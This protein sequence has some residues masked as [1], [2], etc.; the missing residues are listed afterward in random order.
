[1]M[2]I[3]G[4]CTKEQEEFYFKRYLLIKKHA[5]NDPVI[6]ALLITKNEQELEFIKQGLSEGE[7]ASK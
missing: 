2:D 7:E 6:R 1:M 4:P 3:M 5:N